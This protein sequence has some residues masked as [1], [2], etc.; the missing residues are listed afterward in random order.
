[1]II[2]LKGKLER[3]AGSVQVD[4]TRLRRS[5][6]LRH[7]ETKMRAVVRDAHLLGL[8]SDLHPTPALGGSPAQAAQ[9]WLRQHEALDRGW[10]GGPIGWFHQNGDGQCA[11]AIRCALLDSHGVHAYAGAGIVKGSD[12]LNEWRETQ[13]KFASIIEAFQGERR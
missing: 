10:F 4:D 12:P 8:V 7:L 11:V 2:H 5:R 1:M 6:S 13:A 3:I 9:A